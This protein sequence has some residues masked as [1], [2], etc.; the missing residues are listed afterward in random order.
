MKLGPHK[1]IEIT[2][3]AGT[4]KSQIAFALKQYANDNDVYP[5]LIEEREPT[6]SELNKASLR[7]PL[8]VVRQNPSKVLEKLYCLRIKLEQK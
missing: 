1:Y 3:A 2:G 8:L 6:G 5:Y 7:C 4:G